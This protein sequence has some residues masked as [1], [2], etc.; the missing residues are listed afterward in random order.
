MKNKDFDVSDIIL[1]LRMSIEKAKQV[2]DVRQQFSADN[3]VDA[4]NVRIADTQQYLM[5]DGWYSQALPS[6]SD[7]ENIFYQTALKDAILPLHVHSQF[8]QVIIIA[9]KVKEIIS[10]TILEEGMAP[11]KIPNNTSHGFIAL[12][13]SLLLVKYKPPLKVNICST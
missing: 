7:D 5:A 9:G 8:Q 1:K 6:F 2:I 11:Y 3:K 13:D 10:G 4:L 12:E